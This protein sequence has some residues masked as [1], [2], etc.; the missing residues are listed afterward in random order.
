MRLRITIRAV[1]A[2][3]LLVAVGVAALRYANDL[4][5]SLALTGVLL[6]VAVAA[7]G[8]AFGRGSRRA[9]WGG[10]AALGFGYLSLSFGPWFSSAIRPQL[11]TTWLLTY[12]EP[13]LCRTPATGGWITPIVPYVFSSG[14]YGSVNPNQP[15][16]MSGF[17]PS[18]GTDVFGQVPPATPFERVG[19]SIFSLLA[20][21]L[22]GI[23]A[24]VFAARGRH[25]D[26]SG[27][28]S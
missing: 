1:M 15:F 27:R 4:W 5:A 3:V 17:I 22:G 28:A 7:L 12:A 20:G 11:A 16:G 13:R 25:G 21:W 19:H 9:W 14:S 24:M 6:V 10:F 18:G 2:L 23:A 8:A 26:S